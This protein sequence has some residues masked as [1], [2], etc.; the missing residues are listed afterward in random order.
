MTSY[1]D[2][3]GDNPHFVVIKLFVNVEL[4]TQD[5][6]SGHDITTKTIRK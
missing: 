6:G 5:I 1:Y 3:H 2:F 4:T